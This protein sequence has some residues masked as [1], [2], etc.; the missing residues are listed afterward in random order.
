MKT[1]LELVHDLQALLSG[2]ERWTK[3]ADARDRTG[4]MRDAESAQACCWCI[5]GALDKLSNYRSDLAQ[6]MHEAI[7]DEPGKP[8]LL[9][10]WNDDPSRTFADIQAL[11]AKMEELAR[12]EAA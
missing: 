1:T 2:P 7:G 9:C 3:G 11:M 12:E 10:D 8:T 4:K 5:G 6:I